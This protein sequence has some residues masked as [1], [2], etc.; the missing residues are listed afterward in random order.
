MSA[1]LVPKSAKTQKKTE[2]LEKFKPLKPKVGKASAK[3]LV[4]CK[5]DLPYDALM[6]IQRWLIQLVQERSLP[7]SIAGENPFGA[8]AQL[9][10]P[11]DALKVLEQIR[12]EF[13]QSFPYLFEKEKEDF[14]FLEEALKAEDSERL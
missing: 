5:M 8:L 9:L 7:P 13:R 10:A 11:A 1:P 4:D 12:K 14:A 3:M 2:E 6:W